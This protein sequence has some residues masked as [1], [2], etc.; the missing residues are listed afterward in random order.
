MAF[1]IP[2]ILRVRTHLDVRNSRL[3]KTFQGYLKKKFKTVLMIYVLLS[4]DKIKFTLQFLLD[5]ENNGADH[6]E[7]P[8][9]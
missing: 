3:F 7:M 9:T 2:D 4:A 1:H 5:L 8:I 6:N